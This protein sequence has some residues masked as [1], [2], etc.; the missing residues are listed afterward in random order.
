MGIG[1]TTKRGTNSWHGNAVGYLAHDDFQSSNVPDELANDPRLQG[2]D[3]A[4]HTEQI[5]DYNFDLGGPILKDKL[6]IWGSWGREDIRIKRLTQTRDKTELVTKTAKLNWQASSKDMISAFWFL[7]SKIKIGR[8]PGSG[9]TEDDSFLWDQ[10]DFFPQQP[11]GLSKVEWNRT[12]S[13]SFFLNAKWAY[14]STGFTLA[15]RGDEDQI[16]NFRTNTASGNANSQGFLRPQTT[17]QLDG[18][19]F[20]GGLGGNHELR[21]GGSWRKNGAYSENVYAG[22]KT[23]ARFNTTGS[24]RARFYRGAASDAESKYYSAYVSDTFTKDRLTLTLGI[25]W[26]QQKGYLKPSGVPGNTLIPERLPALEFDGVGQ[27][28]DWND[29]S[30]RLGFTLALNESRK[31]LLRGSF[32]YYTGQLQT[33]AASHDSPVG[34]ASYLEYDWR[35]LNGDEMIS[36]NE[37]DF[38]AVRASSN[39]NPNDPTALASPNRIDPDFSSD[40]DFEVVLGLDH[41]LIP[42]LA[43]GVAYTWRKNTDTYLRHLD[44][45]WT[46]RI[47]VT[48]ADYSL[49][50]PVTRNGYT[51]TPYILNA[52]VSTRPGVTGGTVLTNRPDFYRQYNGLELTL[53]KRLSNRWMG[54]IAFSYMDW[55]DKLESPLGHFPN[56]NPIDLDPGL[57]GGQVI[58]QGFG[59]GKAL[60]I[61][62][63]WQLA[64]NALYQLPWNMEIATNIFT[65]QGYPQ[66]FYIQVNTGAFE[67]TTNVLAVPA[68]DDRTGWT[69]SSTWTCGSPRTSTSGAGPT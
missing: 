3:K 17:W 53:N 46:P 62:A 66:P 54:R 60:Y 44:L 32:A 39:V 27:G 4:D 56:P 61:N 37:V 8:S 52:G 43:V 12:F 25:R 22:N 20:F 50:A 21:F 45:N 23:Q 30:P 10:G 13:P 9:L 18:S 65:R 14:Y 29:F 41:E 63:K 51:V 15:G 6:W 31:T 34:A 42:D 49:G 1:F 48:A 35:D 28:I 36:N 19:Y 67:G 16:F 2:N 5:V 40:N 64:A 69:A 57:D 58:R 24:D 47:N 55:Q 38:S 26:D 7:G 59:S 33:G 68:I 11:H